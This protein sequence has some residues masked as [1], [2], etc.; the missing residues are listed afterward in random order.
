MINKEQAKAI[1]NFL[2]EKD[3]FLIT[4]HHAPDGDNLGACIGMYLAL[5]ETGKR[6]VIVNEDKF[7]ERFSFL[8]DT[9]PSP[10]IRY[11]DELSSRKYR[12][13]IIVDTANYD[14]IG[15]V[16]NM[17]AEDAEIVN[18]DHHP[19][20]EMFGSL[21]YVD[22]TSASASE[23]VYEI[24]KEN[25]FTISRSVSDALLSG[26]LSDTGGLR[27]QNTNVSTVKS[28]MDFM[29]HGSDLA[30]LT[31][32]IFMRLS[33]S[34][35]VKVS[36]IASKIELFRDEK[37]A[38]AY[39]DQEKNPLLENEPVLMILNSIEEAEV[40]L[41]VRKNGDDFYKISVRSKGNFNVSEFSER[42]KGGGHKNA[43]GIKF[44][45]SYDELRSKLLKDLRE[46]C[47]KYYGE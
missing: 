13:V 39:N 11:S 18:I 28:V 4:A 35:T 1:G 25:G 17:I 10:Y 38:L 16:S 8:F 26:L 45:G 43:A 33:F 46:T 3:D 47:L 44:Y 14:R 20:N 21:N 42:W 9:H 32:R 31:D 7:V 22:R 41:F 29:S 23:L 30:D 2:K 34:E 40:S 36:E 12:N 24:L 27:F 5:T 19:T 37:L 15:K 6:V